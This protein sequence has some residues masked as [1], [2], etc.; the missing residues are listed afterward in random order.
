MSLLELLFESRNPGPVGEVEHG[1]PPPTVASTP[2]LYT[3]GIVGA[4]LLLASSYWIATQPNRLVGFL[5]FAFYLLMAYFVQPKPD[6]SNFGLLGGVIDHPFRW[7]DDSNR[8]LAFVKLILWPGRFAVVGVRDMIA[9]ARGKHTIVLR[10][11]PE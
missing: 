11:G 1:A 10:R 4:A 3:R 5:L 6:Y 2:V 8:L 7:S 9:R